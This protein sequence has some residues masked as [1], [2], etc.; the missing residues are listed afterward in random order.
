M[1]SLRS[2]GGRDCE[3]ESRPGHG[4]LMYVRVFCVYVVLCLGRGLA[5]S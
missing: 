5:T 1:N 2:L 4:C 3:L